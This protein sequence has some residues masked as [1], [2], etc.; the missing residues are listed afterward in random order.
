MM[1]AV[2]FG[3]EMVALTLCVNSM[4][5]MVL[6]RERSGMRSWAVGLCFHVWAVILMMFG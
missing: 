2:A 6:R 4:V 5:M 3:M 1:G